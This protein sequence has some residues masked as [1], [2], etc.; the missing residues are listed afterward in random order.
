M[1]EKNTLACHASMGRVYTYFILG[2]RLPC[3]VK[4]FSSRVKKFPTPGIITPLDTQCPEVVCTVR[5]AIGFLLVY[6]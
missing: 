1:G 3:V 4:L 6:N 2:A 5:L